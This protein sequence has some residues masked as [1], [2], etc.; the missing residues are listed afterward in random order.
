MSKGIMSMCTLNVLK[1]RIVM[2][3]AA[4]TIWRY[5][6]VQIITQTGNLY[7]GY[8]L[9]TLICRKR[10]SNMKSLHMCGANLMELF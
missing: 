5:F 1:I 9:G 10:K 4:I 8:L 7:V 2:P 3:I 6:S